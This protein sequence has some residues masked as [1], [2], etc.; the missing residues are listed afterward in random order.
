VLD[1]CQVIQRQLLQQRY[2]DRS[3]KT[4]LDEAGV[5]LGQWYRIGPFRDLPPQLNWVKNT[6][7]SFAHTFDVERDT[8]AD[9]APQLD[10]DYPAPN[11]PATP[12]AK[13]RWQAR[14]QW[15][16]G[17]LCNLPRGPAPSAGESQYVYRAIRAEQP[18]EI[19]LDFRVRAPEES[20][21]PAWRGHWPE[22]E[23]WRYRA[24]LRCFLN[25]EPVQV[26][27]GKTDVPSQ[28]K[29]ALRGGVNH[30]LAKITNNRHSYGFSFAVTG[31]HPSPR[32]SAV[33]GPATRWFEPYPETERPWFREGQSEQQ[34]A[35][36]E[37]ERYRET[38]ER[39]LDLRFSMTPMPGIE[40]GVRQEDGSVV[41]VMEQR[42]RSYS[43]SEEARTYL[44]SLGELERGVTALLDRIVEED[45]P[46]VE[47]VLAAGEKLEAHWAGAICRLPE[48]LFLKRPRYG[49]D[50]MQ[51]TTSGAGPAS[52]CAFDPARRRLRTIYHD[53]NLKAHDINLSWDARTVLI[54]GGGTISRVGID[55]QDFRPITSGQSPA[56]LPSGRIV[57][58]DDSPGT[59]PCKSGAPRRL[60]F[61]VDRN[62]EN[63]RL[64]SANLTI[65][66]HP[67]VTDDGCVVFARWDYGVN[68]DVFSRHGIWT[69]NPD[70]TALDLVF[71]NTII[72]PFAFYRPRQIPGRP[73][74]VCIFGSHHTNNAGLVGLIHGGMGREAGDGVGF[75]RITHDTAS[76][77]DLATPEQF[78]DPYPLCEQL[79]LVSYAGHEDRPT[80]VYLLDR[81]GNR[82]CLYEPAD[83]LAAVFPQPLVARER[84]P[85]VPERGAAAA[86]EPED[87]QRRLLSDPDWS[88][89]GTLLLQDVYRGLEGS[90]ERGRIAQI[91][92]MEQVPETRARGGAMGLGAF[93][94]VNRL[95]GFVPVEADGS[96]HFQVPA[97]RS[98]YFHVLDR[99]GKM[100][101]TQGSD[102][103]VMPGER[104]SC[105]GCHEQGAGARAP[106]PQ[107][108]T[109]LAAR[110]PPV[111]PQLPEWGTRGIL[112]YESVV[113]PVFDKHC[114]GCH[115]GATP[116]GRLNLS[117]DRTTV[118]NMSYMELAD[119][120]LVDFMP[121]KG[122][123]FMQLNSDY[124]Q[125]APLSRGSVL[126]KLTRY[127]DDA[128]H[129]QTVLGAEEKQRVFLWIDSNIPFY[130]HYDQGSPS[131]LS[132][133]ARTTLEAVY[134]RRCAS[135]HDK[136]GRPDTPDFLD[137]FSI[138]VHSGPRPG[139]WG[140]TESGM[141]VR[142]LN[143]THPR[144]SAALQA[145]LAADADGWGLCVEANGVAV[146]RD[147]NDPDYREI[148][149]TLESGVV[150]RH[151]PGVFELL[152]PDARRADVR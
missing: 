112:E 109:P 37:T 152:A 132:Q 59:S 55:G 102:F 126:S 2:I 65:D 42:L 6:D 50:S 114:A 94:Y 80:G 56:E 72:D 91:A 73:E 86:W 79:F 87:M 118:F 77:A 101:M 54:G 36:P 32:T 58:F 83:G 13:R 81:Y 64:V 120:G 48:I 26:W 92:V 143:L 75:Q 49:H 119:K 28:V 1:A 5:R 63:R 61:T 138:H 38:L 123:T 141:R 16:D 149:R 78:Q 133:E 33:D 29:L 88:R 140:I 60:L 66:N 23:S 90:I 70:G 121:G 24:R 25:G 148:L 51:Y 74:M 68:K 131:V 111:R 71:G 151:E 144:S 8:L 62:G 137:S 96:A 18:I 30:F 19:L 130:G 47:D 40:S 146:F 27:Q 115:G 100:L 122:R 127:L 53:T 128:E 113:Q 99:D 84:P 44:A 46:H 110:R 34:R 106:F 52:I 21:Q 150:Q 14:Q 135:C 67:Q 69:Q 124:D 22:R 147:K 107:D 3:W 93:F 85:V 15:V 7:S 98:L 104:R 43:T 4:R 57:F 41:T 17:Y 117:G 20:W 11:F 10:R 35:F 134:D 76:V 97:L 82:K 9:G 136:P 31:L 129:A 95:L 89:P 103:H 105:I 108:A 12:H 116:D 125:Q 142:H 145:P 45:D 139:Q 39:L